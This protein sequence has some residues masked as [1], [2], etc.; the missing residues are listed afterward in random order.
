MSNSQPNSNSGFPKEIPEKILEMILD[1]AI[2]IEDAFKLAWQ[3]AQ[4][5]D[6]E[7]GFTLK[8]GPDRYSRCDTVQ[9]AA[10]LAWRMAS[11]EGVVACATTC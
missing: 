4:V 9:A 5:R 10:I 7:D 6:M 11:L 3:C 1:R 2:N 8:D